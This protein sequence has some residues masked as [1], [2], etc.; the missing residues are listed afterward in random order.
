MSNNF[1]KFIKGKKYFFIS[2]ILFSFFISALIKKT[3]PKE[4]I[5][6]FVF[7]YIVLPIMF[8]L[9]FM[10]IEYLIKKA[11]QKKEDRKTV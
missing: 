5:I 3:A 9:L 4:N 6:N 11:R 7:F 8:T 2:F 1:K 10:A